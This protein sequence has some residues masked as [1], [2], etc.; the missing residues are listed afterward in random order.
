MAILAAALYGVSA[1]FSK[2]LLINIPPTLMA[3]L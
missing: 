2:L 3:A 1:P